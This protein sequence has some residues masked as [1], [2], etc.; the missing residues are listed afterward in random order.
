MI[1]F[2]QLLYAWSNYSSSTSSHPLFLVN[3]GSISS[4]LHK[5]MH[6][7]FPPTSGH[8]S[9]SQWP[10]GLRGLGESNLPLWSPLVKNPN[11]RVLRLVFGGESCREAPWDVRNRK[12]Y[13]F[14]I[15]RNWWRLEKLSQRHAA[16][17]EFTSQPFPTNYLSGSSW[18]GMLVHNQPSCSWACRW[19]VPYWDPV[20]VLEQMPWVLGLSCHPGTAGVQQLG[21]NVEWYNDTEQQMKMN[22]LFWINKSFFRGSQSKI[23][24]AV[25]K[26][27]DWSNSWLYLFGI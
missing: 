17:E 20:L 19:T 25:E 8:Y 13:R 16:S 7:S 18:Y 14:S 11:V 9:S 22:E 24:Q 10:L 27:T 6:G 4:L 3:P 15:R 23:V 26:W 1:V 12:I 21:C 2:A 5:S